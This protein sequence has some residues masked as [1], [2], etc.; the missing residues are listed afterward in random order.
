[1]PSTR[2]RKVQELLVQEVSDIVRREVRDPRVG[3]VT[4]TD[5]EVTPDLRHARVFFSVLGDEAAREATTT[6]LNRAAGFVR[7]EFARRAQLRYVPDIQFQFDTGLERGMHISSLLEQVR[8]DWEQ[9][10]DDGD[11]DGTDSTGG[12]GD[13]GSR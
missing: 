9:R 2:Q 13:P 4:I 7:G 12:A 5:A 11:A 10:A 8:A 1:M 3:F 6:A